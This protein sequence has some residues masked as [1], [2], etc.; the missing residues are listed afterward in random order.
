[1]IAIGIN[2]LALSFTSVLCSYYIYLIVYSS[3]FVLVIPLLV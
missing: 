1:K 3:V 2:I